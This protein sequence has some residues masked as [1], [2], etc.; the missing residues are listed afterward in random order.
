MENRM[1]AIKN[2]V[3]AK[4]CVSDMSLGVT[5]YWNKKGH[6]MS[7]PFEVVE[8]LLW[9]EGFKH[10]I[11]DGTLYIENLQDKIDLGIEPEGVVEPVNVIVLSDKQM[12]EYWTSIPYS[13]FVKEISDLPKTQVDNLIQFAIDNDLVDGQKCSYIKE[14]TGKDILKA[15]S[16]KSEADKEN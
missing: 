16:Y 10:M 12:K 6:V 13:V 14:L 5:R 11:D 4:V 1:V 3:N 2:T 8:Q 15:I 9:N 7:F